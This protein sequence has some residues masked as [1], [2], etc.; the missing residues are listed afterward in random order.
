[1]QEQ[2]RAELSESMRQQFGH[3]RAEHAAA[4]HRQVCGVGSVHVRES[5]AR[6]EERD[7]TAKPQA[8][9]ERRLIRF[10]PTTKQRPAEDEQQQRKRVREIAEQ[11]ERDVGNPRT[12][13]AAEIVYAVRFARDMRPR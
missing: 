11:I 5:G 13:A 1:E 2:T 4:T 7:A 10:L 3:P 8:G 9:F 6:D 12:A